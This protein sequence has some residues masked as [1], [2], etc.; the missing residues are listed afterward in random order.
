[1]KKTI[2]QI[3][4]EAAETGLVNAYYEDLLELDDE[5][6]SRSAR[7]LELEEDVKNRDAEIAELKNKNFELMKKIF[8]GK[9]AEEGETKKT[10]EDEFLTMDDVIASIEY[11]KED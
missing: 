11:E 2:R 8:D 5:L 1:M 3:V 7:I 9:E 10:G 4:E 6:N